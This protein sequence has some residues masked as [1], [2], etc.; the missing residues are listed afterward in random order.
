MHCDIHLQNVFVKVPDA[1][2]QAPRIVL[3]DF[4]TAFFDLQERNGNSF[5]DNPTQYF[6]GEMVKQSYVDNHPPVSLHY[7]FLI[8]LRTTND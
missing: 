6:R 8:T 3:A 1:P 7:P 4:D 2:K 5:A